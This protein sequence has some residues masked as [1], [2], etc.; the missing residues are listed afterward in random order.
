MAIQSNQNPVWR[1]PPDQ[2]TL[3]PVQHSPIATQTRPFFLPSR[4]FFQTNSLPI[5]AD[6]QS[7]S[8]PLRPSINLPIH[9]ERLHAYALSHPQPSRFRGNDTQATGQP[10]F[11]RTYP[12]SPRTHTILLPALRSLGSCSHVKPNRS[13]TLYAREPP[14]SR[15]VA[16]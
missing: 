1:T 4:P 12:P 16:V 11:E 8:P 6:L 5:L 7:S 9:G 2:S 3:P 10:P 14:L 15:L 13:D